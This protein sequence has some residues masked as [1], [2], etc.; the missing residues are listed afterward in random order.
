[1]IT[2]IEASDLGIVNRLLAGNLRVS[3]WTARKKLTAGDLG[4]AELPPD[5]LASLGSKK[6]C[7]PTS[8]KIFH[9]LKGRAIGVLNHYG[10]E[11]LGG[12]AIP[13]SKAME[14]QQKLE[15]LEREFSDAKEAFLVN[16]NR[17]VQDWI[18]RQN[19]WSSIIEDSVESAEYVR[20]RIS[21]QSRFYSVA[22]PGMTG[23]GTD[24]LCGGFQEEVSGLGRA[25]FDEVSQAATN[26]WQNSF[27]GQEKVSHKALS[28]IRK[29]HDKLVSFSF[30]DPMVLPV[31]EIIKAALDSLPKHGYIEGL[32][33]IQFQG[34]VS[35]LRDT[36]ALA[37]LAE[38]R[39]NGLATDDILAGFIPVSMLPESEAEQIAASESEPIPPLADEARTDRD[40]PRERTEDAGQGFEQQPAAGPVHQAPASSG[41]YGQPSLFD[42][43]RTVLPEPASRQ[44]T[45]PGSAPILSAP[46]TAA[47]AEEPALPVY[48]EEP[49]PQTVPVIASEKIEDDDVSQAEE[50]RPEPIIPVLPDGMGDFLNGFI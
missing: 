4:D 31:T 3:I 24:A 36:E 37:D 5:D 42:Y 39:M 22:M 43:G 7:D 30:I 15:A 27:K 10:L 1:M 12:W 26:T 34:L 44:A 25:L 46:V 2:T 11:F 6:I 40:A 33:L 35:L 19:E 9:T 45:S 48:S 29:I 38:R 28:L 13:E 41:K 17:N 23:E 49:A 21:F 18:D 8:L 14:V 20:D 50:I 16:Y 32:P 47:A